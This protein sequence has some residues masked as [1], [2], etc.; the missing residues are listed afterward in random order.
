MVHLRLVCLTIALLFAVFVLHRAPPAMPRALAAALAILLVY[1]LIFF[2]FIGN[3]Y[4]FFTRNLTSLIPF[5]CI[6]SACALYEIIQK[7]NLKKAAKKLLVI[8]AIT[9][10][11]SLVQILLFLSVLIT[12]DTRDSA[13]TWIEENIPADSSILSIDPSLWL[14][15][16]ISANNP[17]TLLNRTALVKLPIEEMKQKYDYVVLSYGDLDIYLR[18]KRFQEFQ[19]QLEKFE[20]ALKPYLVK[21]FEK[22]NHSFFL[23]SD[24]RGMTTTSYHSPLIEIYKLN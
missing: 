17:V 20:T 19:D 14:P 5:L 3:Q 7:I 13:Q 16:R 9:W 10:G 21:K 4:V 15:P 8:F 24:L 11:I 18:E 1:P 22:A 6:P 12:P 23:G 2:L